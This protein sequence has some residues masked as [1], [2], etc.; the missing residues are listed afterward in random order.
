[1][2]K[3]KRQVKE[4]GKE[5]DVKEGVLGE[6]GKEKEGGREKYVRETEGEVCE[7]RAS[8]MG[9]AHHAGGIYSHNGSQVD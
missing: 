1:M 2:R 7:G 9:E 4:E 3:R 8:R 6:E 5:I